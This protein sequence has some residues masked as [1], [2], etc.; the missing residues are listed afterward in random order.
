[1]PKIE[2]PVPGRPQVIV[3]PDGESSLAE[4]DRAGI[5]ALYKAHGALLF[6]GF[7]A[8]AE[9]FRNFAWQFCRTS[10]FNE[11]PG[12]MPIDPENNIHTVD[13]GTRAFA[14]H[15]ELSR[16]PWQPDVAFFGCLS[17]PS[18]GG[19]TTICDGIE[20]VRALPEDVRLALEGRRFLHIKGTWPELLRFWLGTPDPTDQQLASPPPWCPYQFRRIDG[21]VIR[22]FTRP[23]FHKPMFA[24]GP[25]FANF[26]L[27]ARYNH[28]NPDY[29]L[30]DNGRPVPDEW[31]RAIKATGDR[32]MVPVDWQPGDVLMVDNSR[33]MHGRTEILDSKERLIATFF[34]YLKFAIPGAEEP[35]AAPWRRIDFCPPLPPGNAIKRE[36]LRQ[37][38]I[39]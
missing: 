7:G 10:V 16:E 30:L 15:A 24:E 20:L 9:A 25:T 11:S 29:P 35:E 33:F 6:R 26:L 2:L 34:G 3:Q 37:Q 12:R 14:L 5:E 21:N 38:E 36:L 8:D 18:R 32:L 28:D 27:F 13:G 19:Q 31:V 17:A 4:L 1:M 23:I 39:D 22:Y